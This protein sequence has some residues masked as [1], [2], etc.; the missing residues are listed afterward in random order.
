MN[1]T[2]A[3]AELYGT[4]APGRLQLVKEAAEAG[5]LDLDNMTPDDLLELL[6]DDGSEEVPG[7]DKLSHDEQMEADLLGRSL[8]HLEIDSLEAAGVDWVGAQEKVAH[9][10]LGDPEEQSQRILSAFVNL[11]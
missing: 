8:A 9:L 5:Q 10:T 11:G 7:L 6:Q 1:A 4:F 3:L 2:A